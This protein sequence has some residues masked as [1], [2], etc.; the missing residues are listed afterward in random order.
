[1]LHQVTRSL[2]PLGLART[3][4]LSPKDQGFLIAQVNNEP[5]TPP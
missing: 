4:L 1:M 2:L 5:P 3:L